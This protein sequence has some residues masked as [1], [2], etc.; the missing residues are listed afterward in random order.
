MEHG[1]RPTPT[2]VIAKR[3]REVRDRR[4]LTAEQLAERLVNLGVSWQRSTVAKLENGK[5]ENVTVTEWLA[6]AAALNVAP[7]HLLIPPDV[8]EGDTYQVTPETQV[9]ATAAR[10]WIRGRH[11][12]PGARRR[13]F[14]AEAPDD[15]W[16]SFDVTTPDGA[17]A[18]ME[19]AE[20]SGL[21]TVTRGKPDEEGGTSGQHR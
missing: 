13:E 7:V 18:A 6:L 12:L 19:W 15:E 20:R 17:R 11:P 16:V 8:G 3:V 5:R 1:E 2:S 14:A 10:D 4:G 9:S 21:G